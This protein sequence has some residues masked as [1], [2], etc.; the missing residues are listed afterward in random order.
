VTVDNVIA[1]MCAESE[2]GKNN[3]GQLAGDIKRQ[4]QASETL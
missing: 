3:C 4:R 1:L 2:R